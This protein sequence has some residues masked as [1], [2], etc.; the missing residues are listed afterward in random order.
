MDIIEVGC[1]IIYKNG[2]LLVAQRHL[3]DSFGGYWEFPGGKREKEETLEACL[4]REVFEEL[5]IQILPSKFWGCREYKTPERTIRLFFYLCAWEY[6]EPL[7]LDCKD[8][9]WIS[10]GDLQ[11]YLWLPGDREV[12]EDLACHWDQYFT[13]T[14]D[15]SQKL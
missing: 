9:K 4:K 10:Q 1:A 13:K 6:G 5:G 15:D 11:K 14:D 7:A 8:F 2:K 3:Q 12:L